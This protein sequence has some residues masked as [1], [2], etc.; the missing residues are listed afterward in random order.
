MSLPPSLSDATP[1]LFPHAS[2]SNEDSQ[3]RYEELDEEGDPTEDEEETD[4]DSE[5]LSGI[6]IMLQYLTNGRKC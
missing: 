2:D 1:I 5:P 3:E 6:C 4:Y